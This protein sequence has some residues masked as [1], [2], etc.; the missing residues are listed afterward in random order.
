VP[1]IAG[2]RFYTVNDR[3]VAVAPTADGGADCLVFDFATGE[4]APD[5]A[6]FARVTPGSGADT[7][8]LTE[9]EFQVRLAA[10][11]ADAGALRASQVRDWARRLGRAAGTPAEVAAALGLTGTAGRGNAVIVDP[12]PSGFGGITIRS[13]ARQVSA[14]LQLAGR[15]LTR[16]ILADSFGTARELP[17][18]PDSRDEGHLEYSLD[19]PGRQAPCRVQVRIRH[20]AAAVVL[21]RC[22]DPR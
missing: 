4:M 6:Y 20:G 1:G 8:V 21:L 2:S 3:P 10:C 13:E 14:Q 18:F 12:V 16:Q 22:D 7:E 5:R 11:R 17:I 19:T 9:A 15:L